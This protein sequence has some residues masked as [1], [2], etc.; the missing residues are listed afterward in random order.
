MPHESKV[1]LNHRNARTEE[2]K[3]LMAKIE[4]D[5]V[6]PFCAEHFKKYHP[7]PILRETDYWFVTTNMSPY[8]GT[9]HHFLLVYKPFH[10]TLPEQ[11]VRE[12]QTDLFA[13]IE[14]IMKTHHIM[15]GSFF[16]RFGDMKY[17]GSSVEH[18]HAH[19]IVGDVD[20]P[21]HQPVK[22]RLG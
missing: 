15:G 19:L 14:W 3:A 8:E 12:A 1:G 10:A 2:Q 5:G 18:L 7:K 9:Q 22:V 6:C 11:V 4:A 20:A 13:S 16:M 17:T 21:D